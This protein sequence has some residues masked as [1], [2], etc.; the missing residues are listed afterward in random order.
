MFQL[1]FGKPEHGWLPVR[2]V[3][4]ECKLCFHAS[5]VPADPIMQLEN[6]LS[7]VLTGGNGEVWFHL[8]PGGYYLSIKN[9]ND[10][11]R[12][13]LD[14]SIDSTEE[15]RERIFEFL[16][17]FDDTIVPAWKSLQK[18]RSRNYSEFQVS[19]AGFDSI[20]KKI[21]AKRKKE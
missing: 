3:C 17:S 18:L 14:C 10:L 11:F 4:S 2:I 19:E 15:R 8:E 1:E 7:S 20:T 16:G 9:E 12:I 5:D 13:T 21:K 6:V